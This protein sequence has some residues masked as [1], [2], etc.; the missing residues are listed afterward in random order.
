MSTLSRLIKLLKPPV[1]ARLTEPSFLISV[2]DDASAPD[3]FLFDLSA[4][5]IE[6]ARRT[7]L[8]DIASRDASLGKLI[9]CWPGEHYRLLGA[10]VQVLAPRTVVEIGTAT[11]A[12]ALSMLKFM[13]ANTRLVTFDL[14]PWQQCPGHILTE[15][16][17]RDGR[18]VQSIDDITV[19]DGLMR[20]ADL[21]QAADL[22]FVDAAKD[23][24]MEERLL[25]LLCDMPFAN[26]AVVVFDDIRLYN[27]LA[28][29]RRIASPKIDLTCFGH[30]TGTG[31]I[32]SP[33]RLSA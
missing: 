31:V 18:L 9:T 24:V 28:T 29:W 19:R 3:D 10:L 32:Y 26:R 27:M 5:A 16:D 30:F 7:D 8:G 17:F 11:G 15:S 22:I 13:A 14:V 2:D 1:R 12:S 25:K 21:V 4:K 23:G 20:H 33:I 6:L